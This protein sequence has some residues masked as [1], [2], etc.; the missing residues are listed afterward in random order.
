MFSTRTSTSGKV[1][2]ANSNPSVQAMLLEHDSGYADLNKKQQLSV[3]KE[4]TQIRENGL[5]VQPNSLIDG[6][7]DVATLI[8]QPEGKVI[9]ALAVSSLQTQ[10]GK[11]VEQESLINQLQE[12][13]QIITE[14]LGC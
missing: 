11:Q 8:G 6:V 5:C 4:L 1:L 10:L 9:A 2:L 13:A 7:T 12:T 3:N 14:Q